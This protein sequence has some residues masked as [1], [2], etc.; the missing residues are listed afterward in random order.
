MTTPTVDPVQVHV[1]ADSSRPPETPRPPRRRQARYRTITLTEAAPV[2]VVAGTEPLRDRLI[3]RAR[4]NDVYVCES[5]QAAQA[6]AAG[7]GTDGYPV[8]AAETAP[9]SWPCTEAVY[10]AAI[11]YPATLGVIIISRESA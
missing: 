8:L 1:V 5:E 10:A 9:V 3:V 6:V 2:A 11:S 7:G 4:D